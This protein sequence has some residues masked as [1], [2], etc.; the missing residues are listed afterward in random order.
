MILRRSPNSL[1][2]ST[3]MGCNMPQ[4]GHSKSPNSS[5]VA[6]ALAGP[7]ACGGC[8]PGSIETETL[9]VSGPVEPGDEGDP[10]TGGVTGAVADRFRYHALPNATPNTRR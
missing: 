1:C 3:R 4:G 2:I 6:G 8:D 5:R 9:D 7:K 10:L